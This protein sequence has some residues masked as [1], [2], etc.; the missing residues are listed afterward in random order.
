MMNTEETISKNPYRLVGK[1]FLIFVST[2]LAVFGLLVLLLFV[3]E[4]DIKKAILGELN[5]KLKA[6]V[7]INPNNIQITLIKSFPDCSMQFNE[8]LV[9]EALPIKKRD[10]LLYA[11]QLNLHFNVMDIWHGKYDIQK[12]KV[13]DAYANLLVFKNGTN[14]YTFW[15]NSPKTSTNDSV[16]FNLNLLSI[17]NCVLRYK[18]KQSLIKTELLIKHLQ[19]KG[20]FSAHDYQLD[21]RADLLIKQVV[22]NKTGFLFDK[23]L[24]CELD[25]QVND[26]SFVFKKANLSLNQLNLNLSGNFV[27]GDSLE[28]LSIAYSAPDLD[29]QSALS[30]LPDAYK[31]RMDDYQSKG[32]FYAEG[33]LVYRSTENYELKSSFGI[34]NGQII[35][36]ANDIQADHIFV[37]GDILYSPK[38]SALHIKKLAA[39]LLNDKLDANLSI[40]DFKQ[41]QLDCELQGSF[42]LANLQKFWPIDTITDI[43]GKLL[44]SLKAKGLLDDFQNRRLLP[45]N[46]F[47]LNADV[48]ALKLQLRG[49]DKRYHVESANVT[50]ND[51]DIEV[52]DLQL[53]RGQ[54]DLLLS[55]KLPGLLSALSH[56]NEPFVIEGQLKSKHLVM[57]DFLPNKSDAE[58]NEKPLIPANIEFKLDAGIESF[59]F[60]KFEAKKIHGDIECKNQRVFINDVA[61]ETA[62][63]EVLL[64]AF[65]D[66][67][68]GRIDVVMQ[69]SFNNIN[70]NKLFTSF[71]NFGQSTLVDKNIKG[72][73][74]ATV[75]F[76]GT[77]SNKLEVNEKS[78][79]ANC[80]LNIER[81]ELHDFKPLESL[82]NY[83]SLDELKHIKF[84]T[85]Q[86]KIEIKNRIITI[87]QTSIKNSALNINFWGMQTFDYDIDYHIQLLLSEYLNKKRKNRDE[88]F[89]PVENDPSNK[90]SAFILMTGNLDNPVIKYDKKG[91]KQKITSDIKAEKQTIRQ[92][93]KE[94]F[95]IFKRDTI[96]QNNQKKS[97]QRFELEKSDKKKNQNTKEEEDDGDF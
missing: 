46:H 2:V 72:V 13:K 29:I 82:S 45:T 97:E 1:I 58:A 6:E 3:Y 49:D 76:T 4:N 91:L 7:K 78:L 94:E 57:E 51:M 40:V 23:N 71:N 28:L 87:P 33:N 26:K 19:F 34:K 74:T 80:D 70:I 11:G 62:D 8:V 68:K 65:A 22:L 9:L 96:K 67:S 54:S 93:F 55:G 31:S 73:A 69:S 21:S 77:W 88:E 85:L 15:D 35:Y 56:S 32:N 30:L 36:R 24:L 37:D 95:G 48:K 75:D 16:A 38:S 14:N 44:L 5:K 84:S 27:Y 89:G 59:V 81:G 61:L 41:P 63:G 90:R 60:G 17:D 66:N 53:Q 20:N 39:E 25:L 92:I 64:N 43:E 52:R 12:I 18:N 79:K 10:T 50:V 42:N 83:V 47:A 86:S